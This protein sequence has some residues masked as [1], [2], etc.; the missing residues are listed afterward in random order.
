MPDAL[1]LHPRHLHTLV[2]LYLAVAYGAD[3][4]FDPAERYAVVALIQRWLPY[5]TPDTAEAVVN[6]AFAAASGG[7]AGT[8][9]SLA[10]D[11]RGALSPALRRQVLADLGHVAR[12]DGL[13]S[14]SEAEIITRV[15]RA[16]AG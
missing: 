14:V 6:T 16:W 12:A 15:R 9:E 1:P 8:P 13:L 11:L 5:L 3:D 7:L 4:D 10:A 2:Q